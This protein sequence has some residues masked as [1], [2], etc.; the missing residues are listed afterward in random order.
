MSFGQ[1]HYLHVTGA[2]REIVVRRVSDAYALVVETQAG[3]VGRAVLRALEEAAEAV[4]REGAI[5][6]PTWEP[7]QNP[8]EVEV[9]GSVAGT[10][11]A[12]TAFWRHDQRTP[13]ADVIGWW[14]DED[15]GWICFRVRVPGDRE[16]TLAHDPETDRWFELTEQDAG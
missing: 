11:Y 3:G 16:L 10:A 2:E 14:L 15:E 5:P 4:R 8:L 1:P 7:Y 6:I 13:V 12:P 9:R